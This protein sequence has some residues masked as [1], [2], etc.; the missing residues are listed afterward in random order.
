M[1]ITIPDEIK[2][3]AFWLSSGVLG[4]DKIPL[5]PWAKKSIIEGSV[6]FWEDE[7]PEN[8]IPLPEEIKVRIVHMPNKSPEDLIVVRN[9]CNTL[10]PQFIFLDSHPEDSDLI[11]GIK[12]VSILP[13]I[14]IQR[15][16]ELEEA[17][18]ILKRGKYYTYWDKKVLDDLMNI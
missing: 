12:S 4:E 7:S 13:L 14:I 18:E 8:L 15:R 17:R 9:F 16:K 3:W 1:K 6:D 5:C 10:D 11:G 2:E